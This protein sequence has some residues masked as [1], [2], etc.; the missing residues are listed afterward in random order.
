MQSKHQKIEIIFSLLIE[1]IKQVHGAFRSRNADRK[2]EI[3][4]NV[5]N[6]NTTYIELSI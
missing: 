2:L 5:S 1:Q 4:T 6:I 3:H